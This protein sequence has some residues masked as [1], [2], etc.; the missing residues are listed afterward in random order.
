MSFSPRASPPRPPHVKVITGV[1]W[2]R[3]LI[4]TINTKRVVARRPLWGIGSEHRA[5]ALIGGVSSNA[6]ASAWYRQLIAK[7]KAI[8]DECLRLRI[9]DVIRLDPK[10]SAKRDEKFRPLLPAIHDGLCTGHL[11]L[12]A[13]DTI[14]EHTR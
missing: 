10:H 9:L 7:E 11:Y 6:R 8:V 13:D 3:R 14:R 12:A 2:N 4:R 1:E 5:F